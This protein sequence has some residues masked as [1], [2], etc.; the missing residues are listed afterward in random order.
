MIV[1]RPDG[2]GYGDILQL[3]QI[4]PDI[5]KKWGNIIY[6]VPQSM[7][8]LIEYTLRPHR[9]TIEVRT[10]YENT[11]NFQETRVW[12]ALMVE[13]GGM[14]ANPKGTPFIRIP[15]EKEYEPYGLDS[16]QVHIGITWASHHIK[17]RTKSLFE[18]TR[19]TSPEIVIQP[20]LQLP[21]VVLHSLSPDQNDDLA[22]WPQVARHD[23][24][25]FADTARLVIELDY[26]VTIDTVAAHLAGGLGKP[27]FVLES[28]TPF[29]NPWEYVRWYHT[30]RLVPSSKPMQPDSRDPHCYSDCM[31]RIVPLIEEELRGKTG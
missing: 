28:N 29:K 6:V 9:N 16:S 7:Y 30:M 20:L 14:R 25:D 26:V 4:L 18:D 17:H 22:E 13:V 21:N 2:C 11:K 10:E 15:P 12:F 31:N 3:V 24:V 1:F 5:Q 23:F 19:S 8:D 27:V